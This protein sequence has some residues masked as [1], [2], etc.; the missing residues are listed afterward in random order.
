MTSRSYF[1]TMNS[2]LGSVVPLALFFSCTF[3][4]WSLTE[5]ILSLTEPIRS[6]TEASALY[7]SEIF[8]RLDH[9]RW[10]KYT[11]NAMNTS[12]ESNGGNGSKASNGSNASNTVIVRLFLGHLDYDYIYC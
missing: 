3:P 12:K 11:S 4:L 10:Y 2:T 5:N 8:S 1:G 9:Y 6:L 7:F